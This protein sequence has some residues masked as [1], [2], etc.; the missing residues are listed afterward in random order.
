MNTLYYKPGACSLA[1]HILLEWIGRDY[2]A[3]AVDPSSADFRI[4]NPS[5]AVP[6]LRQEDGSVLTQSAAVLRHLATS[7]PDVS[8]ADAD[9]REL[10]RWSAFLTGDLHPAFFPLFRPD[11]YTTG[12]GKEDLDGVRA[13]GLALV[14]AKLRILDDRLAA[15]EWLAGPTRTWVDAY[16]TPMLRWA[17]ATV[18]G[19]LS[20]FPNAARHLDAMLADPAVER[21][22]AAEG[23]TR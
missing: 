9:E 6:A 21:A 23:L 3:V 14:E 5:A 17:A 11:R 18:P 2:E 22:M 8:L 16:A 19:G 12:T 13:A 7:N 15:S 1:S 20:R 10:D 4:I